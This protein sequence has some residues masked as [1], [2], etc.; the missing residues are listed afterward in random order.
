VLFECI[1]KAFDHRLDI[2]QGSSRLAILKECTDYRILPCAQNKDIIDWLDNKQ[3]I[4]CF[5]LVSVIE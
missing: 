5:G 3:I 2:V 4:E 1:S